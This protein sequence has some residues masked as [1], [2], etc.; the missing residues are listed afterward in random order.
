MVEYFFET[1]CKLNLY[2]MCNICLIMQEG[3]LK[4]YIS[5]QENDIS[6]REIWSSDENS[7]FIKLH[8]P[9]GEYGLHFEGVSHSSMIR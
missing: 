7:A 3:A 1:N 4:V 6:G 5:E 9:E 8:L 2:F